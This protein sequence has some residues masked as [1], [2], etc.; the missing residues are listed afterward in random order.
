[1]PLRLN[2]E[3]ADFE[4][5]FAAFLTTKR[6]VS[7]DVDATVRD[8]IARVREEGDAA[9][10]DYSKRFDRVDLGEKGIRIGQDEIDAAAAS[11]DAETMAALQLAHDRIASHHARQMPKDDN[12]VDALGVELGSRWT[13]IR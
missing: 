7:E 10:I 6:E 9:L 2:H 1:M 3:D 5:R 11:V 8:I 4:S 12:Y 13:A